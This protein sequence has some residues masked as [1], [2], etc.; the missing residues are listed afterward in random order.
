M[1]TMDSLSTPPRI[2]KRPLDGWDPLIT[3]RLPDLLVGSLDEHSLLDDG[4][5]AD[6]GDEVRRV[7]CLPASRSELDE[8]ELHR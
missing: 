8:L 7:D 5:G 6:E 3:R 2:V 1:V 4:A